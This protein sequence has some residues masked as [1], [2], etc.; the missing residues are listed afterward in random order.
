MSIWRIEHVNA[1][2]GVCGEWTMSMWRVDH[3]SIK[4]TSHLFDSNSHDNI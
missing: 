4:A 2:S 1:D 3:V